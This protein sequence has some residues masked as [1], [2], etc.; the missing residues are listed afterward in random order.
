MKKT[1]VKQLSWVQATLL[2]LLLLLLVGA[3]LA[4]EYED[5][6]RMFKQADASAKFFDTA[7]GYVKGVSMHRVNTWGTQR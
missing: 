1:N 3:A 4:D 5:A 6:I 7:Y 2:S